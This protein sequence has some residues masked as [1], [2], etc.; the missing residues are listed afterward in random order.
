M[1]IDEANHPL[2]K[3][4]SVPWINECK[5]LVVVRSFSKAFGAAGLKVGYT[6][7]NKELIALIHKQRPMYEIDNVSSKAIE[8]LMDHEKRYEVIS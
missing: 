3:E 1:L 6:L 7:A 4:T 8:I 5:H 2:Y